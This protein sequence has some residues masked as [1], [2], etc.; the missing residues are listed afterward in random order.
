MDID[1]IKAVL[2]YTSE[3][4]IIYSK[5][6]DDFSLIVQDA[7]LFE[8]NCFYRINTS[9]AQAEGLLGKL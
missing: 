4:S 3:N 5:Y 8:Q 2:V 6:T 7:K 1:T 9:K